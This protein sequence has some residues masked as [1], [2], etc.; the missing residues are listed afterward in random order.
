M[1]YNCENV[2][3]IVLTDSSQ[4]IVSQGASIPYSAPSLSKRETSVHNEIIFR[5][6]IK[7]RI[8]KEHKLKCLHYKYN[9]WI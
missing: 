1:S 5:T 6:E 2:Q 8:Y 7:T 4:A 3:Y 9:E